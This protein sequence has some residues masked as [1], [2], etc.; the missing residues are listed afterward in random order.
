MNPA[1]PPARPVSTPL[2]QARTWLDT[3]LGQLLPRACLLCARPC[4]HQPLCPACR[5][6]GLPGQQRPRCPHCA[7]LLD[8]DIHGC[9]LAGIGRP[10]SAVH[11]TALDDHHTPAPT[12][13]DTRHSPGPTAVIAP[14]TRPCPACRSR[15]PGPVHHVWAAA[16][17]A[18]PLDHALT[19]LK[20]GGELALARPLGMLLMQH[21]LAAPTQPLADVDALVPIPL[22]GP[23][24]A[25]RGFNQSLE[26][27]RGMRA[28]G[29]RCCP[30]IWPGALMRVRHAPPQSSLDRSARLSNLAGVF[31][32]PRPVQVAGRR[33]CLVDDVMTTGSTLHTAAEA[34]LQAGA[35]QIIA[36]VVAR[37]P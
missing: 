24:L 36:V 33:L 13:Q 15:S 32:V 3:L 18:P 11:S 12:A 37:T 8:A 14:A 31:A 30:P 29:G 10:T 34:L 27:A 26:I 6:R 20:F 22:A 25:E 17:Y 7:Q 2:D 19:A 1:M 5:T 21:L 35:R 4:G 28:W 16:D 9:P 23:R